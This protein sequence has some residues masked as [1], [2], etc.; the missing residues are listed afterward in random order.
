MAL[1]PP[2][3]P[4]H[5]L[6]PEDLEQYPVWMSVHG[7]DEDEKWYGQCDETT[8]RPWL[9]RLPVE[10]DHEPRSLV[11]A[12]TF[13]APFGG[14]FDGAI[15]AIGSWSSHK[16]DA[17]LAADTQP[18]MF[19]NGSPVCFWGGRVGTD[20]AT[21]SRFIAQVGKTARE[22]FPLRF[23]VRTGLTNGLD[24]GR[25]GGFYRILEDGAPGI[26]D[27]KPSTAM[28]PMSI[29]ALMEEGRWR[30]AL[31]LATANVEANPND[32]EALRRRSYVSSAMGDVDAALADAIEAIG[33]CPARQDLYPLV[34]SYLLSLHQYEEC[35][36]YSTLG[37]AA[38]FR[39]PRT[40]AMM[41]SQLVFQR[42]RALYGLGRPA[43]ALIAMDSL[44]PSFSMRCPGVTLT[45]YQRLLRACNSALQRKR[46]G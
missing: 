43:E 31:T 7:Q 4:E 18:R 16:T 14:R 19:V 17:E 6:T 46:P 1:N 8:V 2:L 20:T 27:G 9:G 44:S 13:L 11:L 22:I 15:L 40:T 26:D 29:G 33:L 39:E 38:P 37:S 41:E 5:E 34:C 28:Q 10:P 36:R 30:E 25:V 3:R 21:Q 42:A 24:S 35:L 23:Q 12:A 32:P 45:T